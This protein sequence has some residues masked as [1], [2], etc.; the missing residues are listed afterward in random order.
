MTKM[1]P[2][3]VASEWAA[4]LAG[5]RF[6]RMSWEGAADRA[7]YASRIPVFP[8]LHPY[9]RGLPNDQITNNKAPESVEKPLNTE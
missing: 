6:R 7:F 4:V 5:A 9:N 1:A 3:P 2:F 8:D